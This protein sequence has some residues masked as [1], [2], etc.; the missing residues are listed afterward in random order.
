MAAR[1]EPVADVRV[2][3]RLL[4]AELGHGV[5]GLRLFMTCVAIASAMLGLI[6]LLST[7]LSQAMQDNARRILGGDVA[8]TVVNEPLD[9]VTI[10]TLDGLG[11][12]SNVV[13]LRST[14]RTGASPEARRVTVELKAVDAAYPLVGAVELE[15]GGDLRA[16]LAVVDGIPGA[17][18][19]PALLSQLGLETGDRIRIGDAVFQIRDL[20]RREPDRLS[21]GTFMVGPRVLIPLDVLDGT[22]LTGRGSLLEYRTRLRFPEGT[23]STDA[24]QAV[25]AAEP[26]RGWEIQ[27]PGDAAERVREVAGRTTTFL[28]VAGLAAFAVGLTGA[29]A[30]V[31]M[32]IARRGRTIAQYRLSGATASTVV[33]LHAVMVAIAAALAMAV[34]LGAAVAGAWTLLAELMDRLHLGWSSADMGPRIVLVAITLVLG[35]CGATVAGLSTIARLSPLR[36]MR[37]EVSTAGP[38]HRA[39][40]VAAACVAG[41]IG[42]AILGL[43]D[44]IIA[45]GAAAGLAV[46]AGLLVF[47]GRAVARAARHLPAVRFIA[48]VTKQGISDARAVMLR[49][50]ALGIGIAGITGV[51]SVQQSLQTAF[52]TQ[53]PEKAPDMVLLDVQSAQVARIRSIVAETQALGG[54]Q[55]TPFMRTRLLAVNGVPAEQALVNPDKDWVIEGDRSFS[56][57]STPTGA[58]LVSGDWWPADYD[59]PPLVSAEEDVMQAF[60]LEP[61]D[62]LT[63]SVLGRVFTSRVVNIRKE[64]HRTMRPEFLVVASP[65]PFRDAPHGWI[66]SL[67]T[68]DVASQNEFTADLA[69]FA[70]NVTVI[71]VR[72]LVGEA[73]ELVEVAILGTLLIASALLLAGAL[74]LAATVAADVDSRRREAVALSVVGATRREIALSRLSETAAT[75]LVAAVVGGGTGLLAGWWI[76]GGALRVDWAPGIVA[77]VLPVAIGVVT[78][79][80]AGLSGGLGALPRGRGQLMRLLNG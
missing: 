7:G 78:S 3:V 65:H 23:V 66:V 43:P 72:R 11:Q 36:A 32:W 79:L 71:D 22:G 44:P 75:G 34:G 68:R 33:A 25:R 74:S 18:V 26:A 2:I 40:V 63:Y 42:L 9:P 52:A 24:M 35:L 6:W 61:G 73:T 46:M 14:A 27:S 49:T 10:G 56:W 38:T 50:L 60:D 4:Q 55:A 39:A 20:L 37:E 59:G 70:P 30:A 41:A 54:L 16:A 29:W 31:A 28:G 1:K 64:Y 67:Q 62:T 58:E 13:E 19:E 69:R 57:S 8:V 80:V 21:A 47:L 5:L 76:V 48:L 12:I 53:I 51:I 17:V 45:S 15:E 77:F